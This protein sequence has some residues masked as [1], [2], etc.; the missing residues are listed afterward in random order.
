MSLVRAERRRLVKRRFTRSMLAIGIAILITIVVS[1]Y[2][3]NQKIDPETRAAAQVTADQRYQQSQ[4]AMEQ[5]K[6]QCEAAHSAGKTDD[7]GNRFPTN[8]DDIVG[9]PKDQFVAENFLPST[10]TF[11]TSFTPTV[12]V[13]AAL[14]AL[15]MFLIGAS[16]VGAEWTSGG[17]MNLL[18]WQPRRLKVYFTKLGT[19]LGGVLATGVVLSA[20][21]TAAFWVIA[22]LRGT[23][24]KVTPGVW[25]SIALTEARGMALVLLATAVGFALASIGRHTA[26]ALGVTAG[27]LVVFQIGV[28]FVLNAFRVHYLERWI[29]TTYIQAWMSK[30]TVL[31]DYTSCDF[32]QGQCQ[33]K[34]MTIT[35]QHSGLVFAAV[36]V[37]LVAV[38]AWQMRRRDV[39]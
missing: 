36:L 20:L 3:G 38:G 39:T 2:F 30:K 11:R 1:E 37:I 22:M 15:V 18:L 16:F 24:A 35:W 33:P 21:W 23:T 5:Y 14:L 28:A 13:F 25:Q 8:C 10:F 29:F 4:Q 17:M 9:P 12:T 32:Q 31:E 26:I 27:V 34:T 19:L 6:A 7:G